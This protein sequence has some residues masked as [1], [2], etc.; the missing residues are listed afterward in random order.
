MIAL[1]PISIKREK[2]R[3]KYYIV[4]RDGRKTIDRR[5]WTPDFSTEKAKRLFRNNRSLH[6]GKSSVRLVNVTEIIDSRP[7][8][9]R[10][11]GKAQ[12]FYEATIRGKR[13]VAR[14]MNRTASE[15]TDKQM[16][17]EAEDNF[18]ARVSAAVVGESDTDEARKYISKNKIK[19]R[20][21]W[22]Y[23]KR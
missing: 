1:M 22:V 12:Y 9:R 10:P 2:Y 15:K 17:E 19:V 16:R 23:Y 3:G 4:A 14:S 18:L 7:K 5:V 6:E 11:S 20:Q 21:G 8:A 13:I